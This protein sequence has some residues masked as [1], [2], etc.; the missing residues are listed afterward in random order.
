MS[1][2]VG[3]HI[4]DKPY[5]FIYY[6]L[7]SNGF[8]IITINLPYSIITTTIMYTSSEFLLRLIFSVAVVTF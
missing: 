2:D 8:I 5:L 3:K 7:Y 1:S 4:R 6:R